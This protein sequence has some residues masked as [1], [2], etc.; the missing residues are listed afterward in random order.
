MGPDSPA[1]EAEGGRRG[2]VRGEPLLYLPSDRILGTTLGKPELPI[3]S[4]LRRDVREELVN[5][6]GPHLREHLGQHSLVEVGEER[7][8][9]V[10]ALHRS[11]PKTL[12]IRT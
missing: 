5:G 4:D 10:G 7:V 8:M 9:R 3:K 11:D 1:Q 12:K 2:P 6:I